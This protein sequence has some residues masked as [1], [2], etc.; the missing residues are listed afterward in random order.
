M[1]VTSAMTIGLL[2]SLVVLN[3]VGNGQSLVLDSRLVALTVAG[4]ALWRRV[5]YLGVVV[6]GALAAAL[7]RAAG[8]P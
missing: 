8:L 7:A 2:A 3:A 5:P 1:Q 6:L 4:I